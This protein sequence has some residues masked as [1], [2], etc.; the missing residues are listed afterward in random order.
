M[1]HGQLALGADFERQA[2]R[3]SSGGPVNCARAARQRSWS[4]WSCPA[5]A[6]LVLYV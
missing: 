6:L 3:R 2:R 4:K 5:P 1:R